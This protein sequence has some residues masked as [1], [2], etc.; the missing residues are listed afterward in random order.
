MNAIL[1]NTVDRTF[2]F[3]IPQQRDSRLFRSS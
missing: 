3:D 2:L 1:E